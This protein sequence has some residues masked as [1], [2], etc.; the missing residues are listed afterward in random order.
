MA[1]LSDEAPEPSSSYE[2][3]IAQAAEHLRDLQEMGGIEWLDLSPLAAY[4]MAF[5]D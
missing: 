1:P 3:K 2:G 4:Q 5:M